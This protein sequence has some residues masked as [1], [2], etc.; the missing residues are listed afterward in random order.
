MNELVGYIKSL[1][2]HLRWL[3]LSPQERYAY[4]WARTKK[5]GNLD[6]IVLKQYVVGKIPTSFD[7][8]L[9][10]FDSLQSLPK[11]H[12]FVIYSPRTL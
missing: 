12:S 5:L 6:F 8:Y 1:S 4:L 10:C 2:F 9:S 7:Y 11:F 3:F